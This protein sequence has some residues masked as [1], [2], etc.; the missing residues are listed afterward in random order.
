MHKF[1]AQ[2]NQGMREDHT[3]YTTL[4]LLFSFN[5][6][7]EFSLV[8]KISC[9]NLLL[10]VSYIMRFLIFYLAIPLLLDI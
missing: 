8:I 7:A 5:I 3:L 1:E 4:I 2:E 9:K 10:A 6:I